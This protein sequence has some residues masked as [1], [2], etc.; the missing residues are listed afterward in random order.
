MSAPTAIPV[1][2]V[3]DRPENLLALEASLSELRPDLLLVKARC[4]NDALREALRH[5]FALILM[6]AQ[7]P[8]MDGFEVA[9][10]MRLNPRT[11]RIPIIFMTAGLDE[12]Q[13]LFD[14][15]ESGA[16]DFLVKPVEPVVLRNK[17]N[18]FCDLYAQRRE[19]EAINLSLE[20]KVH[21]LGAAMESLRQTHE[22][23]A[24]SEA[25]ATLGALIAGVAHEMNTA[26]GNGMISANTLG[27]Q[28]AEFA[29]AK[30]EGGLRRSQLD[31]FVLQMQEGT[32]LLQRNLQRALDLMTGFQ[33]MAADQVSEQRR[34]FD[35]R[36]VLAE[37]VAAM[38]PSLK[39][40]SH[41]IELDVP[42]GLRMES[43]PGP[44]EQVIINLINNAYL[45]AF[46]GRADGL[47]RIQVR[48]VADAELGAAVN[49]EVIDNGKGMDEATLARL[50]E[51]FFSTKIGHG[52]TGLGMAIV[53]NIV[54][55]TLGGRITV[56]STPG[57]GSRFS[58][59]LPLLAPQAGAG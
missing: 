9:E 39:R 44:L 54:R 10:L 19:I 40:F 32:T 27:D 8:D 25:K 20:A 31:E 21:E 30:Q 26:L 3:D 12:G 53:D 23:L 35:L 5:A 47:L 42:E 11:R 6:D 1:L 18:V 33:H 49:L 58:F 24:R 59:C 22:N 2:L 45:H 37:M 14:G 50:F 57:Q 52:G 17:I 43:Y 28:A 38:A 41:R 36:Q 7:M 51:P 4:G 34:A 56:R 16:V 29:R 48:A 55:K 13:H 15:Y 46:E